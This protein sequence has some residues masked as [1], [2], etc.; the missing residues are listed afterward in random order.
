MPLGRSFWRLLAASTPSNLAD[1]VTRVALPLLAATL[2]RDPVAVAALTALAFLPWL[3]FALPAGALVDR[4]D[5][6]RAMA[7]ANTVRALAFGLLAAAVLTGTAGLPVLYAVAFTIGVAET[8]YDSAAR[9]VLPQVVTRDQL[10]RGNGLLTT[11]ESAGEGFVGAPL[12][13]A[14]FVLTA[15]APFVTNAVVYALAV[16]LVLTIA[17]TSRPV[18]TAVAPTTVRRDVADGVRW[19]WAHRLLRGLTAVSGVTSLLAALTSGVLVLLA[20]E[21]LRVTEAGFGLLLT[22]SAVGAV[23][24]GLT[25]TPLARRIGR[26]ATLVLGAA[27][28]GSCF[29]ALGAV[30][31]PWVAGV[32]L[33]VDSAAV[34]LWNVLTMSLRQALIPEELFGRVQGAYRT[35]VW[36]AIPVGALLGGWLAAATTVPTVFLVAGTGQVLV[37]GWLWRLLRAHRGEVAGALTSA[38]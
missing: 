15:A 24:G 16:V 29:V 12:G 27:L 26:T 33:A 4:S 31:D 20:L 25:A 21:T 13:S 14:L 34:M 3:L 28:A 8:V 23:A 38:R 10:D 30:S 18:R 6:P 17:G 7:L 37:S 19:L 36:G 22:A 35:V 11:G 9:A 2:T 5:R 32:L 1:G